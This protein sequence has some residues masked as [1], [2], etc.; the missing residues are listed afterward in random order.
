MLWP[1]A[2]GRR[3]GE[4][5]VNSYTISLWNDEKVLETDNGDVYTTLGV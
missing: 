5:V 4:L 3:N 1:G 2:G